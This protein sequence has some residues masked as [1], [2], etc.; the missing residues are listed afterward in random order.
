MSRATLPVTFDSAAELKTLLSNRKD[1]GALEKA[2]GILVQQ[3]HL[4]TKVTDTEDP[5]FVH[6]AGLVFRYFEGSQAATAEVMNLWEISL[7]VRGEDG[8]GMRSSHCENALG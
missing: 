2:L 7:K 4:A 1:L 6:L 5:E 8:R 3:L